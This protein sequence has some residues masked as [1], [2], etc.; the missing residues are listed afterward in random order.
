MRFIQHLLCGPF[1]VGI[2]LM[3]IL[4]GAGFAHRS[5]YWGGDKTP[6]AR[7]RNY[8]SSKRQKRW[9]RKRLASDETHS[10]DVISSETRDRDH[11]NI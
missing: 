5:D 1:R 8:S 7:E 10:E 9:R 2:A 11:E 6:T 3:S 4:G